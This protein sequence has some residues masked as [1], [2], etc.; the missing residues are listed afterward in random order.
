MRYVHHIN[1]PEL[2]AGVSTISLEIVEDLPEVDV[3]ISPIGGGSAAVGH[4]LV[5][6]ALRP[7]VEVIGVQARGAPAVYHSWRERELQTAGIATTAEGLATGQAYY[8][9][10][11]TFIDRMDEMMLVSDGEM[12]QAVALLLRA[13][14]VVAEESGAAATAAAVKLRER[15]A[16]KKVAIVVSGGNMT[17]D[18]LRRVLLDA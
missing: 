11:K 14:H 4:C 8:T 9:A 18:S 1:S 6:K 15:L 5:A 3:I 17:L 7:K 2:L 13:A 16:G 10:V 12:R